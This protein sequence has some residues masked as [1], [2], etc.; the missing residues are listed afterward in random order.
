AVGVDA[1]VINL[2]LGA[3]NFV[4]ADRALNGI[5]DLFF[6]ARMIFVDL[7]NLWNHIATALYSDPVADLHAEA[8][9]LVH[10]MQGRVANGRPADQNRHQFRDR[11][12]FAGTASLPTN[13]F[14]FGDSAAR[15]IL[16]GNR[17]PRSLAGETEFILQ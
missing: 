5:L 10:V 17:P 8:P 6:P 14:Q 9:N 2:A 12:Q 3:D 7:D 4:S 11:R 1:A 15:R 13:V 16:V